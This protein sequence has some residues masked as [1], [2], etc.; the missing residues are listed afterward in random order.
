M[1]K[2]HSGGSLDEVNQ[3]IHFWLSAANKTTV[4]TRSYLVVHDNH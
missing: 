1:G 3:V 2:S 4:Y